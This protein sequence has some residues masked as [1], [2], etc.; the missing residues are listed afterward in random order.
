MKH[1]TLFRCARS[2]QILRGVGS[3]KTESGDAMMSGARQ[4]SGTGLRYAK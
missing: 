3:A 2:G 1:L 4:G